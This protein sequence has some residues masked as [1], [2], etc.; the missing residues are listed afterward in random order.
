MRFLRA[1]VL[2]L[3]LLAAAPSLAQEQPRLKLDVSVEDAMLIVQTLEAIP[4]GTV[5]QIMV[6][7]AALTLLRGIREQA[8]AQQR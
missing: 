5:R 3:G 6:C 4:C 2:L 1:G 8:K 7:E